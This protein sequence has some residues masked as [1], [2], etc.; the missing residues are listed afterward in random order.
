[1]VRRADDDAV[2]VG[3]V[4]EHLTPVVKLFDATSEILK[5]KKCLPV[6]LAWI[7]AGNDFKVL[8]MEGGGISIGP[9]T[10]TDKGNLFW[11]THGYRGGCLNLVART[12]TAWGKAIEQLLHW[13]EIGATFGNTVATGEIKI[14][15]LTSICPPA[16]QYGVCQFALVQVRIVDVGDF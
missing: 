5:A 14:N 11:M 4:V 12:A 10:R 15:I 7:G 2:K 3:C 16:I 6:R 1:M 13:G 9:P 8:G